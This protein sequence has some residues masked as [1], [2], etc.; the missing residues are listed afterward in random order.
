MVK[1]S[2]YGRKNKEVLKGRTLRRTDRVDEDTNS[3]N[4]RK[5]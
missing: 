2:G 3:K 1:Q 4:L 5:C